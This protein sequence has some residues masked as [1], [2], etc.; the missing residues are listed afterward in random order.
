MSLTGSQIEQ[1][2][3][4]L[5]HAFDEPSLTQMVRIRLG[6]DI[7]AVAGGANLSDLVFSL[8]TWA[9]RTGRTSELIAGASASNPQNPE[10][11]LFAAQ[12]TEAAA[13]HTFGRG[14]MGL[15]AATGEPAGGRTANG[16]RLPAMLLLSLLAPIGLLVWWV[17][18]VAGLNAERLYEPGVFYLL[19][20]ELTMAVS[21]YILLWGLWLYPKWLSR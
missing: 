18:Y 9:E 19:V 8:I 6:E 17:L 15:P 16:W 13:S 1:L 5:L 7:R 2:Q 3:T 12:Y 10:L 11:K 20:V 4:A 21:G 14:E